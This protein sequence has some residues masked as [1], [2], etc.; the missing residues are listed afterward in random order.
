MHRRIDGV[1][2][3]DH[4]VSLNLHVNAVFYYNWTD[5]RI[6]DKRKVQGQLKVLAEE[7]LRKYCFSGY[8]GTLT[9]F[10]PPFVVPT[11]RVSIQDAQYS[12]RAGTYHVVSTETSFGTR[13]ARRKVELGQ[14][15]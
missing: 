15:V 4:S 8:E 1:A 3:N 6:E 14:K 5:F 9:A 12:E 2:R 13:G 10:L 7:T 11:D